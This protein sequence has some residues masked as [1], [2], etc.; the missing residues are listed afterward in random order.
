[1]PSMIAPWL[2]GY[3][4]A[5]ARRDLVAGATVWAARDIG[6][7]RDVLRETDGAVPRV[8]GDVDGAVAALRHDTGVDNG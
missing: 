4:P 3:R 5:W 7:V 8:F 1:M 6:Q 2:R